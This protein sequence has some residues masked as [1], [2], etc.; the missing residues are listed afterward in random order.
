MHKRSNWPP[1]K[2][3]QPFR[4]QNILECFCYTPLHIIK[5]SRKN[6]LNLLERAL[7]AFSTLSSQV[8]H[9]LK[10]QNTI[11]LL[12]DFLSFAKNAKSFFSLYSGQEGDWSQGW[13]A[14]L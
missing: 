1:N 13:Q 7:H 12:F 4:R 3:K 14:Q 8:N 5:P 11:Y 9:H 6:D 10:P 2:R